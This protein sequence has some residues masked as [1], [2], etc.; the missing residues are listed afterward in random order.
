MSS[1]AWMILVATFLGIL[2]PLRQFGVSLDKEDDPRTVE[3][4]Q[5][6]GQWLSGQGERSLETRL[7]E[8]SETFLYIF[9]R[10]FGARGSII[11]DAIWSGLILSPIILGW[12]RTKVRK[13]SQPRESVKYD[14]DTTFS[15]HI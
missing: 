12:N 4:R 9:K 5:Q 3:K 6:L 11:Q 10:W 7:Q 15:V 2:W 13:V 8:T 14:G 1:F